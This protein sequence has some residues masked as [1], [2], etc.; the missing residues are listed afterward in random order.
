LSATTARSYRSRFQEE[1]PF[2]REF[3]GIKRFEPISREHVGL[4][5]VLQVVRNNEQ[6]YFYYVMEL[7]DDAGQN[8]KAT[9]ESSSLP[10]PARPDN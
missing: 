8:D 1:R 3:E 2:I 5:D 4:V 10:A 7:A 6:G 9:Q